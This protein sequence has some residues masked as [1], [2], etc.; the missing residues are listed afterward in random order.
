MNTRFDLAACFIGLTCFVFAAGAPPILCRGRRQQSE[1]G[2]DRRHLRSIH[3]G[4]TGQPCAP[5][6]E[7]SRGDG[8]SDWPCCASR[9]AAHRCALRRGSA[10]CRSSGPLIR[11]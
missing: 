3:L 5:R 1:I 6:G 11:S 7:A 8:F 4:F 2:A 10:L 9:A